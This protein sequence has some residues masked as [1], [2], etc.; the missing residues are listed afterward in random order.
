MREGK[1][2]PSYQTTACHFASGNSA[3]LDEVAT[4]LKAEDR[5]LCASQQR[6]DREEELFSALKDMTVEEIFSQVEAVIADTSPRKARELQACIGRIEA[7][8]DR[9]SEELA[10]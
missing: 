1:F 9:L 4:A 3:R 7:C 5:K 10:R 2:S 8:I 6:Q